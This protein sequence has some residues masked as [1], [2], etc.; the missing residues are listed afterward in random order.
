MEYDKL[1]AD[2]VKQVHICYK[3]YVEYQESEGLTVE[4]F[5]EIAEQLLD[6]VLEDGLIYYY[7]MWII[8]EQNCDD[9][10]KL[11][12]DGTATFDGTTPYESFHSHCL[13]K[14]NI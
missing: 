2:I 13:D 8:I 11:F 4:P 10:R 12:Y 7:Q 1:V 6:D 3:D 9:T 14:L 5:E